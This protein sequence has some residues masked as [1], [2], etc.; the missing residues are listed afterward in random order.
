MY[1]NHYIDLD[2]ESD[3]IDPDDITG[4]DIVVVGASGRK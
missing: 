1:S 2:A 3:E 4:V